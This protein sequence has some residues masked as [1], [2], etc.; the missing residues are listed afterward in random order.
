MA[1]IVLVLLLAYAEHSNDPCVH[2]WVAEGSQ[3]LLYP[4]CS[5]RW[6]RRVWQ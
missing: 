3:L 2:P 6:K 1:M 4:E 5:E